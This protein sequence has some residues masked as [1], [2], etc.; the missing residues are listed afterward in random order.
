MVSRHRKK[1]DAG[2]VCHV[3]GVQ[4]DETNKVVQRQRT[5]ECR[6]KG[7]VVCSSSSCSSSSAAGRDRYETRRRTGKY[8]L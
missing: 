6:L 8:H 2:D 4:S 7:V 5:A 1:N 3:E